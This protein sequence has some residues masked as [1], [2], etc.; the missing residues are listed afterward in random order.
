MESSKPVAKEYL[1]VL[2]QMG[3]K[4]SSSSLPKSSLSASS[5]STWTTIVDRGG[6]FHVTN[7]VYDLFLY[8]E[9]TVNDELTSIFKAKGRGIEKIRKERLEWLCEKD[10]IQLAWSMIC[11]LG[12]DDLDQDLLKEIASLWI[13]T[14]GFSKARRVKEDYKKAK[15]KAAAST[16]G[17]RS[18]R[19]ELERQATESVSDRTD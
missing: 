3:T 4:L 8:L 18:L 1:S 7:T 15:A 2:K 6:L 19:K 14:R 9:M 5:D 13:T 16:K 12:E 11:D 10:E 17:K